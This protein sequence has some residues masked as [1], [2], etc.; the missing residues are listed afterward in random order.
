MDWLG[1]WWGAGVA[2]IGA[3][4]LL[5]L[6]E[7][8]LPGFFLVFLAVGAGATGL[9][10]VLFPLPLLVQAMLFAVFT[11]GAVTLGRRYY[12]RRSA[13]ADPLLNER[14][15]RL[16]GR[17]VTVSE[18]IRDGQGRVRI[19]DGEWT[20]RGPDLPAGSTVRIV[21]VSGSAVEVEAA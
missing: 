21:A 8:V 9:V 3:A 13:S 4:L 16:V 12:H 5:A 17:V 2:W 11:G 7:L 1:Q 15:A 18:A 6:A 14:S 10:L 19:G 20:A